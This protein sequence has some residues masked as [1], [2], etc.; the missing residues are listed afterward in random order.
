MA[1]FRTICILLQVLDY[2]FG[3]SQLTK[4]SHTYQYVQAS[5]PS[6]KQDAFVKHD[7]PNS[8][9]PPTSAPLHQVIYVTKPR[10]Q[11]VQRGYCPEV[12]EPWNMHTQGFHIIFYMRVM[13]S[14]C[15]QEQES[16]LDEI[17]GQNDKNWYQDAHLDTKYE[18]CN[19]YDRITAKDKVCGERT[20][21]IDPK[22]YASDHSIYRHK[23]STNTAL[24]AINPIEF[25]TLS[26]FANTFGLLPSRSGSQTYFA[27]TA[28]RIS[29]R[30]ALDFRSM[31]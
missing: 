15:Q 30:L 19:L 7:L 6:N 5:Y 23:S 4:I 21:S 24:T 14:T 29:W 26:D 9:P 31:V 27:T 28:L 12:P 18:H 16:Q 2:S 13:G 1:A 25:H 8:S 11:C 10:S 22:Q 3:M 20:N 17:R